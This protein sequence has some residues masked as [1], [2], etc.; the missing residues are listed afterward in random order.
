MTAS[1][2]APPVPHSVAVERARLRLAVLLHGMGRG[3]QAV[4]YEGLLQALGSHYPLLEVWDVEPAKYSR[5]IA[6]ARSFHPDP[7]V[8]RG[9]YY[10]HPATFDRRTTALKRLLAARGTGVD[11]FLQVGVLCDGAAAAKVAPIVVYTDHATVLTADRGREFRLPL[12]ESLVL[13]RIERERKALSAAAHICSRSRF[14]AEAF[15]NRYGIDPKKLSVVGGGVNIAASRVAPA[16]PASLET[17]FLFVG[18]EYFRKG[19]DIV[20][21]AFETLHAL[22]PATRLAMVTGLKEPPERANVRWLGD[23]SPEGLA[24]EY[25]KADVFVIASRF[26]TWGDVLIEAMAAGLVCIC[27]NKPPFDEI[28]ADGETGFF[29]DGEDSNVLAK[30]MHK[31]AALP[32]RGREVGE[33]ARRK[34]LADFTWPIVAEK[35]AARIDEAVALNS[36]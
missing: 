36:P 14:V 22:D 28:V 25:A 34:V 31:V 12:S 35:I 3:L 16:G 1:R 26:E 2:Q 20:L 10:S 33:A 29:F 7:A 15:V 8:W 13:R 11:A 21:K 19:G 17:R 6:L 32:G 23:L 5:L 4:K 24:A 27:P 18:K 9:R 30:L